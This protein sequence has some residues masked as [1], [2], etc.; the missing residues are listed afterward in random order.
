MTQ[1]KTSRFNRKLSLESFFLI[2]YLVERKSVFL[3]TLSQDQN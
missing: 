2:Y 3:S 1:L